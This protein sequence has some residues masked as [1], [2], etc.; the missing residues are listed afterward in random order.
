MVSIHGDR[1]APEGSPLS[2]PGVWAVALR[3]GHESFHFVK[4]GSE[5]FLGKTSTKAARTGMVC[6][7][8]HGIK[9][10]ERLQRRR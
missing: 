3:N 9:Y 7:Y 5:S 4:N 10:M 8:K 6:A 1:Q 2:G